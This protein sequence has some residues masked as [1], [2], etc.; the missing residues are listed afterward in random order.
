MK[1][2]EVVAVMTI[3]AIVS[4]VESASFLSTRNSQARL[5]SKTSSVWGRRGNGGSTGKK[6]TIKKEDLPSKTCVVC[7]RPFSWRK[8]WERCWDE[9]TCC[10]KACNAQRRSSKG[11]VDFDD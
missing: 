8:K 11:A 5:F 4:V 10:S 7:G 3:L 1:K 6:K 2:W 9:V